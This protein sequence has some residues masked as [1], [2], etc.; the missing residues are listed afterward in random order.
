[1]AEMIAWLKA[2]VPSTVASGRRRARSK[3]TSL[4]A[5]V[6]GN[7]ER[8]GVGRK[9]HNRLVRA[10]AQAMHAGVR[11]AAPHN[12]QPR[13]AL[14][15]PD[16]Y[17]L[18]LPAEKAKTLLS[19]PAELDR[20]ADKIA[21]LA[22]GESLLLYASPIIHVVADP[23][24]SELSVMAEFS[25][26]GLGDSET[27]ELGDVPEALP[28]TGGEKIPNAF[29]IVNGLSTYTMDQAVIN[30]GSDPANHLVLPGLNVAS[31]HA[32][33]RFANDRFILFNLD[34]CGATLV[35]GATISS[36]ALI[37]GDVIM[38]AGVPLVYGQDGASRGGY[39]Q[40]LEARSD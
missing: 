23:H 29:L 35:N 3:V 31:V 11:Q 22:E 17:T 15:A 8:D 1:M 20:L 39:T 2:S 5:M 16:Q 36:Q 19:H 10:L 25:L 26:P 28:L 14:T 18:V 32:Q 4:R 12:P 21:S 7:G 27:I 34:P 24:A 38:L 9:L 40:K 13:P 30:I 6:E 37:P 33:V